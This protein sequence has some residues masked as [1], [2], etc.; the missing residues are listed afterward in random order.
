M[1]DVTNNPNVEFFKC[2]RCGKVCGNILITG[3]TV[4]GVV[5]LKARCGNCGDEYAL[6]AQP[7]PNG[8]VIV[9]D[10]MVLCWDSKLTRKLYG[11]RGAVPENA[12]KPGELWRQYRP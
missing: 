9:V 2:L 5:M 12:V 4:T 8:K 10:R 7:V 6:R 3:V 11:W 1:F